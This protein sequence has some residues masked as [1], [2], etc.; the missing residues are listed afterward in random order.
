LPS[1]RDGARPRYLGHPRA[2]RHAAPVRPAD[3][4]QARRVEPSVRAAIATE[5]WLRDPGR[6][7]RSLGRRG[8]LAIAVGVIVVASAAMMP[9]V[10]ASQGAPAQDAASTTPPAIVPQGTYLLPTPAPSA[11]RSAMAME[12]SVF[13]TYVVQAGD[14]LTRIARSFSLS[15]TTLY[16]AN[17]SV[18]PNPDLVKIGQKL[19]IPPVDGMVITVAADATLDGIADQY[20][21]DPQVII[22][23]N[24]LP[25]ST[26]AAGQPLLLPGVPNKPLPRPVSAS[27]PVNWLNKLTWPVP[28]S[29]KL[30]LLFGC[31]NYAA[32][33]PFGNCRHW[34]SGLDVG[35]A[36]WG[37]PVVA[38]AAGTVIY[39][40]RRKAGTDGAAGGI[41]VWI[42]HGG[43]LYTTYNHL[44][45][46]TVKAGQH[47]EAGQQVGAIGAT[48]AADG[49][50]LH[51]EVWIDYPWTGGTMADA[52][53]PLLYTI[54]KP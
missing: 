14:N 47:V 2:E 16:W 39:A 24:Q 10:L 33:P 53:D 25:G 11:G 52:R 5:F 54:W 23:A 22:D 27:K 49:A 50:H 19:L 3:L 36:K 30:T 32:E 37:A 42:S 45:A 46:V 17:S 1:I 31:T 21:I 12:D 8:A 29:H 41:V 15:V 9:L 26:L 7:G 43:T 28:S 48:G 51:F 35:G 38:A 13:S 40:G 18:L 4:H 44:S 34:H 6:R 20:G